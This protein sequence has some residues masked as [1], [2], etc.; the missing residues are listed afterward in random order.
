M[1]VGKI[2]SIAMAI[3]VVAGITI[4]V[5]SP[6]TAGDLK[7]IGDTFSGSLRAAMGR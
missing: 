2:F 6:T 3:V 7:A 5:S 4:V 1:E